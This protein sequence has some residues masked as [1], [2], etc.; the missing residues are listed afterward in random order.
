MCGFVDSVGQ[1]LAW[2]AW[3]TWVKKLAWVAWVAWFHNILAC[4][5]KKSS[6]A[7]VE[8]LTWVAWVPKIGFCSVAVWMAWVHRMFFKLLSFP[9]HCNCSVLFS[10]LTFGLLYCLC[11]FHI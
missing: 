5:K 2:V 3:V 9:V 4:V 7:W 10:F 1:T 6:V 11:S 8:I